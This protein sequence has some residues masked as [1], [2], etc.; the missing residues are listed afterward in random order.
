MKIAV[1]FGG[2]SSEHDI[3]IIT[4]VM[5]VNAAGVKH[6]VIPVYVTREGRMLTGKC[7][8][9]VE[10]FLSPVKGK[11][12][13]FVP[14][15]GGMKIGSRFVHID[16]AINACHGHGGE[17]GALSG[18][19][20]L[21]EIPYVGSSVSASAIGMDKWVFKR[22]MESCGLPVVPYFGV[23]R[24]E[25]GKPDFDIA[26]FVD[27]IGFPLIV[28]PCNLGSSIGV[29]IAND[30]RELFVALDAAFMWD[31]RAVVEKALVGF[32]EVNCAVLG[33]DDILLTS[34]VEQPVGFKD[35]LNF[36]DKYCRSLKTEVRKMPAP[37]PDDVRLKVRSLSE[38][39]FKAVGCSGV[40]RTD[41]LIDGD[42][43]FVNEINTVPGSLSEYLFGYGG[44]TFVELIDRLISDA[45]KIKEGKDALKYRYQSNVLSAKNP[46]K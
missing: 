44:M 5:A 39:V 9:K 2:K 35:F 27:K 24:Y 21:C 3:S 29:G 14:A 10:H 37:L 45:L 23:N 6:E 15:S 34:E 38:Q 11:P 16:C 28:K 32:T 46:H 12:V 18:L 22:I 43:I 13:C 7:F 8:D 42:D 40:A 1:I 19:L 41:F 4:G 36:D 17:D 31:R 33:Y 20:E 26:S 25:Y 30:F